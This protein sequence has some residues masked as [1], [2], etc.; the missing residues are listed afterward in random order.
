MSSQESKETK[1]TPKEIL[2]LNSVAV[3]IVLLGI[4]TYAY[5]A[6]YLYP[7][8][9][10]QIASYDLSLQPIK[11]YAKLKES[12]ATKADIDDLRLETLN[13]RGL[14][15]D[16]SNLN[17]IQNLSMLLVVMGLLIALYSRVRE[18]SDRLEGS[19]SGV[20]HDKADSKEK[21]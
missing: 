2:I 15:L 10:R 3:I 9:V 19:P 7:K 1:K 5:G 21:T 8:L 13:L 12:P 20:P 6:L 16:L 17:I 14:I 11:T 18:L 4:I